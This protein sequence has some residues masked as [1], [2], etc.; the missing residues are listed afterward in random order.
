MGGYDVGNLGLSYGNMPNYNDV[1]SYVGAGVAGF[2][3][4]GGGGGAG[5]ARE[6]ELLTSFLC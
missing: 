6:V 3:D 1:S 2:P 4:V 5:G